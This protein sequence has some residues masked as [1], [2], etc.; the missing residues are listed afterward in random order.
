[1]QKLLIYKLK[2]ICMIF[3]ILIIFNNLKAYFVLPWTR[4][5]KL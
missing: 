3:I 2:K 5:I 1:M 4:C